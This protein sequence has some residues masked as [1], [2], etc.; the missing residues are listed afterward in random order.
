MMSVDDVARRAMKNHAS[1]LRE[2]LTHMRVLEERIE[3]LE[4][5]YEGLRALLDSRRPTPYAPDRK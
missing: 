1:R 4:A 2:A 5:A 3:A